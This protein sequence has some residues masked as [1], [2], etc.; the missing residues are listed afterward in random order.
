MTKENT[1]SMYVNKLVAANH[2]E[3]INI[4]EPLYPYCVHHYWDM[5]LG[6]SYHQL[7]YRDW[8]FRPVGR[9]EELT[10]LSLFLESGGTFQVSAITGRTGNGKSG[11]VYYF[12]QEMNQNQEWCIYGV[13]YEALTDFSYEGFAR[14]I[15]KRKVLL[16]IDYVLAYAEEIGRWIKKLQRKCQ[17]HGELF[18]RILLIERIHVEA[19]KKP[20]WYIELVEKNRIEE[21]CDYTQFIKLDNLS[22]RLLKEIFVEYIQEKDSKI[23]VGISL[24]MAGKII[25]RLEES[26]KTPLFMKYIADAWME[27]PDCE[28]QKWNKVETLGYMIEKEKTRISGIFGDN[29]KT[30]GLLKILVYAIALSGITIGKKIPVCLKNEWDLLKSGIGSGQPNI[31]H[32]LS[33]FVKVDNESMRLESNFPDVLGELFCLEY[34]RKKRYEALDEDFIEEFVAQSWGMKP[35]A[36]LGFLCRVI[37]DFS[38]HKVVSFSGILQ[39]PLEIQDES[40]VLYADLLREYSYWNGDADNIYD[41]I[42]EIYWE[43]VNE[44]ETEQAKTEIYEKFAVTLFN[45][46]EYWS[47]TDVKKGKDCEY[48]NILKTEICGKYHTEKIDNVCISAYAVMKVRRHGEIMEELPFDMNGSPY[49]FSII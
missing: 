27:Q 13:N 29:Q 7:S 17:T 19:D 3:N 37:E 11:L 14:S 23:D 5:D 34:L 32:I 2:I 25:K 36:F 26:C 45:M 31:S 39:K 46:I 8:P 48:W 9:E 4:T 22:D 1:E 12:Y 47:G 42:I 41:E 30:E 38:E 21:I 40:R 28:N 35:R 16:V 18:I 33:A 24:Q 15:G 44:T 10:K 43:L 20:Y 49:A 6:K